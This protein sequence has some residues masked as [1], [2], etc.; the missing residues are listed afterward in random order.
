[1]PAFAENQEETQNSEGEQYYSEENS[2]METEPEFAWDPY[3]N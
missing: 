2:V 1:M 3:Q